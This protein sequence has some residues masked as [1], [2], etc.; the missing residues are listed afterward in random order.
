MLGI[1]SGVKIDLRGFYG[2]LSG[3]YHIRTRAASTCKEENASPCTK[4]APLLRPL[5]TF[6]PV[7]LCGVSL[8]CWCLCVFGVFGAFWRVFFVGL[9]LWFVSP[10]AGLIRHEK[11]APVLG[12]PFVVWV[13]CLSYKEDSERAP[14]S[15]CYLDGLGACLDA[16]GLWACYVI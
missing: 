15:G 14:V 12:A 9:V 11:S 7:S 1:V 10:F 5:C 8:L 3:C 2:A 13:R 16:C 4:F 6:P